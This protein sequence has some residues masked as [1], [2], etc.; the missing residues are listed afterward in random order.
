MS[1]GLLAFQARGFTTTIYTFG[2]RVDVTPPLLFHKLSTQLHPRPYLDLVVAAEA[3]K[4]IQQLQH[5]PLYLPVPRLLTPESFRSDRVQ[6][7][8]EDDRPAL[9]HTQKN[10]QGEPEN[11]R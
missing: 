8:D 4:L 3:V 1:I 2:K 11:G 9:Y 10:E 6:L 5:R 7:V